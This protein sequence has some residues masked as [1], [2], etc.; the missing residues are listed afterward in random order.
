MKIRNFILT[1]TTQI[2]TLKPDGL[3][4]G[5]NVAMEMNASVQVCIEKNS[6]Y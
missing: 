6:S 5:F 1:P 4:F 2:A 3:L